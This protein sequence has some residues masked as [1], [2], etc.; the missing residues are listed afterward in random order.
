MKSKTPSFDF[1]ILTSPSADYHHHD[2]THAPKKKIFGNCIDIISVRRNHTPK[3]QTSLHHSDSS[4]NGSQSIRCT[5]FFVRFPKKPKT[6]QMVEVFVKSFHPQHDMTAEM[7]WKSIQE[8]S[9]LQNEEVLIA[10][11]ALEAGFQIPF[12]DRSLFSQKKVADLLMGMDEDVESADQS[13]TS[14]TGAKVTSGMTSKETCLKDSIT[15]QQESIA[16]LEN[17]IAEHVEEY[18][19]DDHKDH[20]DASKVDVSAVIENIKEEYGLNQSS[21]S[22][23]GSSN[24][25]SAEKATSFHCHVNSEEFELFNYASE[26]EMEEFYKKYNS[27]KTPKEKMKFLKESTKKRRDDKLDIEEKMRKREMLKQLAGDIAL[28]MGISKSRSKSSNSLSSISTPTSPTTPG[29]PISSESDSDQ[30]KEGKTSRIRKKFSHLKQKFKRTPSM[31]SSS[32]P[33]SQNQQ[34]QQQ[35]A[36]LNTN[37]ESF[38]TNSENEKSPNTPSRRE[39][40][41]A[42]ILQSIHDELLYPHDWFIPSSSHLK[43]IEKELKKFYDRGETKLTLIFKTKAV[44]QNNTSQVSLF[45]N[46]IAKVA[47]ASK[48]NKPAKQQIAIGR[49]YLWNENDKI[50][51][52]DIDGTI[53]K[54]DVGG[55]VASRVGKDYVHKDICQTYAEIS[56]RGYKMLYLTARPI[57]MSSTTRHF[58][59]RLR[60]ATNNGKIVNLPEGPVFTAYNSGTNALLREVIL[61]R[62][63]TFKVYMLDI[64]LKTFVPEL[65]EL[66]AEQRQEV[67]KTK[68]PF[69]SGFGNRITDDISMAQLG[70]ALERIFRINPAGKIIIEKTNQCFQFHTELLPSLD[71][72]F[73]QIAHSL[74]NKN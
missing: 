35:Q 71:S 24:A 54:S 38:M 43:T 7:Y 46:N 2:D 55:Q 18:E 39:K 22:L 33:S 17:E 36:T 64:I 30:E 57:T 65:N 62:P 28:S 52:S 14:L 10:T 25:S 1:S 44:E 37:S 53:T 31:A 11:M 66:N 72:W 15:R 29:T 56:K 74:S 9:S 6:N 8:N 26:S 4:I 45:G 23:G 63:D 69:F 59:E 3:D 60:Q 40:W 32:Q 5:P 19:L 58:I 27:L 41:K 68:T 67:L 16:L 50:V 20:V 34:K 70:I 12:F 51:V 42:K 49:L 21:H 47:G 61:K 13:V 73:Q 48:T